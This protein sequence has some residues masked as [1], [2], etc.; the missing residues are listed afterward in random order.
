MK[1]IVAIIRPGKLSDVREALL[2]EPVESFTAFE[3]MGCGN[4]WGHTESEKNSTIESNLM[5]KVKI[6]IEI[7]EANARSVMNKIVTACRSGRIG[8]G[9]IFVLN[10]SQCIPIE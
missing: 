8:D 6:E 10:A 2:D 4:Q 1:L 9:K 5:K 7:P 3:V